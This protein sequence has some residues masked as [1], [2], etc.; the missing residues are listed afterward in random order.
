[1]P[2]EELFAEFEDKPLASA[3]IAQVHGAAPEKR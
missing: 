3:S 1:V 2:I